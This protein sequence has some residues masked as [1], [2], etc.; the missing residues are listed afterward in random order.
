[1]LWG[2]EKALFRRPASKRV[3]ELRCALGRGEV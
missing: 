2:F 3:S 1:L